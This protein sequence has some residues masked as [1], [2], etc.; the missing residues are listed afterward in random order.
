[1]VLTSASPHQRQRYLDGPHLAL[2]H[3]LVE[4][5]PE[6][7][8]HL[9]RPA[10]ILTDSRRTR[11]ALL[12]GVDMVATIE[13]DTSD[14][15]AWL[16][17]APALGG[18]SAGCLD[19]NS[20]LTSHYKPLY[21]PALFELES[22]SA[23]PEALAEEA[24]SPSESANPFSVSNKEKRKLARIQSARDKSE[25]AAQKLRQLEAAAASTTQ[26]SSY[27]TW[28]FIRQR[29]RRRQI[30]TE[31]MSTIARG[32]VA[33]RIARAGRPTPTEDDDVDVW[34]LEL[35]LCWAPRLR[36]VEVL[37]PYNREPS[38]TNI[39]QMDFVNKPLLTGELNEVPG[40]GEVGINTLNRK[41]IFTTYQVIGK[42]LEVR[43]RGSNRA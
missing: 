25:A 7:A 37:Y 29:A 20:L 4:R 12:L 30:E 21:V 43:K 8:E 19:L 6:L 32:I 34:D 40:L 1:M 11:I 18:R 27:C 13:V 31:A 28:L 38:P 2:D 24:I 42:F 17:R 35:E 15:E 5:V 39:C 16:A 9:G 3:Q 10:C 22:P 36:T 41:G 26:H 14:A 33:A 23:A